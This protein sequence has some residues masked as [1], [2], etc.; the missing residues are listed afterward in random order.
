MCQLRKGSDVSR[1]NQ[2]KQDQEQQ[3]KGCQKMLPSNVF[4]RLENRHRA[5]LCAT[6]E[7][8]PCHKCNKPYPEQ[9]AP[10]ELCGSQKHYYCTKCY[11]APGHVCM[12]CGKTKPAEDFDRWA[13]RPHRKC[14]KCETQ[15]KTTRENATQTCLQCKEA[16]GLGAFEMRKGDSRHRL[17]TCRACQHPPCELCGRTLEETWQWHHKRKGEPVVCSSCKTQHCV[18]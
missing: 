16:K 18:M 11:K 14:R 8:P 6:C 17:K 4:R 2:G 12:E 15:K 13:D 7:R 1:P 3:C 10:F 9:D 5:L